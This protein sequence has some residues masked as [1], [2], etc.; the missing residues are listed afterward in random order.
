[1]LDTTE[2]M[3][4]SDSHDSRNVHI[5]IRLSSVERIPRPNVARVCIDQVLDRICSLR[6]PRRESC[7]EEVKIRL[8]IMIKSLEE[9]ERVSW[10]DSFG[11]WNAV[12]SLQARWRHIFRASLQCH[13]QV[14]RSIRWPIGRSKL[15][16]NFLNMWFL[17]RLCYIPIHID[18]SLN[19][20]SKFDS[21]SDVVDV[22]C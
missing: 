1:M 22:W 8:G 20:G 13:R 12:E 18:S 19:H 10:S 3:R 21:R 5:N 4:E 9:A 7:I 17:Q 6:D 11:I 2:G 14:T 16:I 15:D